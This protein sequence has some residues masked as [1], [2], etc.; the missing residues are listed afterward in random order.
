MSMQK[1]LSRSVF[2]SA[3]F[4]KKNLVIFLTKKGKGP[5]SQARSNVNSPS[6][7]S[8]RASSPSGYRLDL[9]VCYYRLYLAVCYYR[10]DLAVCYYKIDLA[11]C[12]Y[13]LDLAVCY[14]RIDLALC[15]YRLDLA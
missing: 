9:A 12:Y 15:Y 11:L 13:R 14:Y 10:I 4:L 3:N 5:F 2:F 6:K 1:I 7:G 8:N